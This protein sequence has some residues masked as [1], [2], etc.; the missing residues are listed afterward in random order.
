[1]GVLNHVDISQYRLDVSDIVLALCSVLMSSFLVFTVA[2]IGLSLF[3]LLMPS[4]SSASVAVTRSAYLREKGEHKKILFRNAVIILCISIIIWM[5]FAGAACY[6]F[7][8]LFWKKVPNGELSF[9][10]G[11]ALTVISALFFVCM[12]IV[13]TYLFSRRKLALDEVPL[14]RRNKKTAE[15]KTY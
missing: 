4:P 6:A 2:R 12:Q 1:M 5:C 9:Y 15:H 8:V 3:L 14:R 13:P 10:F 7:L 11:Q